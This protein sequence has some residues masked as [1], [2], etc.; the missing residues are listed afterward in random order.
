MVFSRLEFLSLYFYFVVHLMVQLKSAIF[1]FKCHWF[2]I[3]FCT[4]QNIYARSLFWKWKITWKV[5]FL[6]I[7]LQNFSQ[8]Y[9][10]KK[11]TTFFVKS[12]GKLFH[13]SVHFCQ[14]L[15]IK[16]CTLTKNCVVLQKRWPKSPYLK[17]AQT[18]RFRIYSPDFSVFCQKFLFY[19]AKR[20][21]WSSG[22]LANL[23]CFFQKPKE[24]KSNNN[25][26]RTFSQNHIPNHNTF[27][28][29]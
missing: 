28:F 20:S 19:S 12:K 26:K 3:N 7:F 16:I 4:L 24:R 13:S 18:A 15:P 21:G 27:V 5:Q 9:F 22:T 25:N 8:T 11:S 14:L 2:Q 29:H 23:L 10:F 6:R 17:C 1:N